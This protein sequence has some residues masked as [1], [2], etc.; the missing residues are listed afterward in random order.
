M[1]RRYR[2]PWCL[3][4]AGLLVAQM[5]LSLAALGGGD[6]S[7]V[8]LRRLAPAPA[9]P[10]GLAGWLA[11][12]RAAD[13]FLHDHFGM[14]EQLIAMDAVLRHR[15]LDSGSPNVAIGRDGWLFYR[16]D[17]MLEQSAGIVVR[18]DSL[19]TTTEL[20][21]QMRATLHARGIRFLVAPPPN[22][23]SIYPEDL[24]RWAYR[25]DGANEYD[26]FMA[27][28]SSEGVAALD[29]RPVL[30]AA[31]STAPAYYRH[32]THW[33]SRGAVAAFNAVATFAGQANWAVL[34]DHVLGPPVPRHDNDLERL[35]DLSRGPGDREE[36]LLTAPIETHI[37]L[38]PG[39]LPTYLAT[40]RQPGPVIM[41]IGDSFTFSTF[42]P[43]VL[44]HAGRLIWTSYERCDFDWSLIDRF[45]PD[46]VWLMPTE[47][48]MLCLPGFH[49]GA[50]PA[51]IHGQSP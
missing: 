36:P 29:L 51:P 3:V 43:L 27:A 47:R 42:E 15:L 41:I 45:H 2:R 19:T 9:F 16:G 14:R 1:T 7:L 44:R 32:D 20:V 21:T 22:A 48:Y 30:R 10:N 25:R 8:E 38:V 6:I 26:L 24:P 18:R 35:L 50:M 11:F 39:Q 34:P 28:L 31:K 17:D 12:P 49:P 46:Q 13:A 23:S 33:T 40:G 5:I 4:A 37:E